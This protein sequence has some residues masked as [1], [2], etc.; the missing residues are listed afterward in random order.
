MTQSEPLQGTD[1]AAGALARVKPIHDAIIDYIMAEPMVSQN[2]LA[3]HF[4]YTTGWMSQL[5]NSD[6]FLA[7]LAKRKGDLIDPV[8][9]ASVEEKMRKAVSKSLDVVNDALERTN[10]PTMALEVLKLHA[11]A[12]GYGARAQNVAVQQNFVVALPQKVQSVEAWGEKYKG[13]VPLLSPEQVQDA[14]GGE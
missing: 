14:V 10:N 8:I 2:D 1:S 9:V 6:A 11:K 4:G 12:A 3:K 5:M 13:G 7:R